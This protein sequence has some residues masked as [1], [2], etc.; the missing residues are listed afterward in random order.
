MRRERGRLALL[1][2]TEID[3]ERLRGIKHYE[4]MQ[5]QTMFTRTSRLNR[6]YRGLVGRVAEAIDVNPDLLHAELK[7]KAGLIEQ[8]LMVQ[9]QGVQ[10]P[11]IAVRLRSTAFPL[12]D[13]G[14]FS[15][16]C[17]IA[18]ELLFRDYCGNIRGRRRHQLIMEWAG[19]RPS[20]EPK[21]RA[22]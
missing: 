3:E 9:A 14:D 5:V 22:A 13:D 19:R 12:M 18:V 17:D 4:P 8:V 16:Y 15:R 2:A 10:K 7:F 11:A 6:W 21:P 1:P 20:L